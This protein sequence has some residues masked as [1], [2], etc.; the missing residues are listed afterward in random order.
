M[1]GYDETLWSDVDAALQNGPYD[2][3]I[4]SPEAAEHW[5]GQILAVA[6]DNAE[7]ARLAHIH[8]FDDVTW[9]GVT[10]KEAA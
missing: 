4:A 9:C 10:E 8:G 5:P 7:A 2:A 6:R 1:L 3:V